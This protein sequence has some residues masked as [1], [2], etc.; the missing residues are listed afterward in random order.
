MSASSIDP[1]HIGIA[2]PPMPDAIVRNRSRGVDPDLIGCR[3]KSGGSN[4]TLYASD[5]FA[6]GLYMSS[7][8][9]LVEPSPVVSFTASQ[10]S[11]L[12]AYAG[13][14]FEHCARP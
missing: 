8:N 6:S 4:F 2:V 3:M 10:I 13:W 5:S 7:R 12:L 11:C 14:H 9:A 1:F